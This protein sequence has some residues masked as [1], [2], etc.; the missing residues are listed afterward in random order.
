MSFTCINFSYVKRPHHHLSPLLAFIHTLVYLA[1]LN[2]S[3]HLFVWALIFSSPLTLQSDTSTA[4]LHTHNVTHPRPSLASQSYES[5]RVGTA[6]HVRVIGTPPFRA[7]RL[8]SAAH[9]HPLCG[10]RVACHSLPNRCLSPSDLAKQGPQ[11][12]YIDDRAP[13]QRLSFF[14]GRCTKHSTC[15]MTFSL[16]HSIY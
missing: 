9:A 2:S 7:A 15:T 4:A 10:R 11:H 1:F 14:A 16:T 13:S 12:T 6:L 3:L 5:I 8:G